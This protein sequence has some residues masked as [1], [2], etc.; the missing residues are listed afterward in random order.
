L[1]TKRGLIEVVGVCVQQR[2]VALAT[3]QLR[4]QLIR[5]YPICCIAMRT[6]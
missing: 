3:V 4:A 2:G 1:A 5:R 6:D